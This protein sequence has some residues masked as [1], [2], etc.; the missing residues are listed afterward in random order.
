MIYS[1][2]HNHISWLAVDPDYR[3]MGIGT[4]LVNFMFIELADRNEFK[5]KTFVNGE[6]Q[7]KASHN[8]YE[9]LGFIGKEICY[10]EMERNAGHPMQVFY[11]NVSEG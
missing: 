4:A 2:N 1:P 5:V 9:S 8:F 3:R 7:S 6:W 11:K 10:D